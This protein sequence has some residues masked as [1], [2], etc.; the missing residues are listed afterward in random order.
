MADD[1]DKWEKVETGL[2]GILFV[3][4]VHQM[5]LGALLGTLN[6]DIQGFK[7]RMIA[8][9]RQLSSSDARAQAM[10]DNAVKLV[11]ELSDDDAA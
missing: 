4:G 2:L 10:I 11:A 8:Y 7:P 6:Q 3:Q 1:Q 5:L 9:L